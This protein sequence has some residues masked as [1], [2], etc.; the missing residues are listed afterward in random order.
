M[1]YNQ[2]LPADNGENSL[3]VP[4]Y[5]ADL[6]IGRV[7]YLLRTVGST[8][9]R[10]SS[11]C[12]RKCAGNQAASPNDGVETALSAAGVSNSRLSPAAVCEESAS[13]PNGHCPVDRR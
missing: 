10:K 1:D 5:E 7:S 3:R 9:R 6:V 12:V 4:G 8:P 2:G 13:L 11:I